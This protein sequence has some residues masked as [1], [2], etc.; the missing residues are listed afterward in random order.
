MIDKDISVVADIANEMRKTKENEFLKVA[1]LDNL[2]RRVYALCTT[3]FLVP[4]CAAT[5]WGCSG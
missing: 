4:T 1:L 2:D 5:G 3:S